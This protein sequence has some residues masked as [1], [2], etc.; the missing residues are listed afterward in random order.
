MPFEKGVTV[1]G[2]TQLQIIIGVFEIIIRKLV[3]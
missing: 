3:C 2:T 1:S